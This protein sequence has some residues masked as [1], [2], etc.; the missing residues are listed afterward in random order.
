MFVT[1]LGCFDFDVSSCFSLAQD[2]MH[3]RSKGILG[4]LKILRDILSK[5][6][7]NWSVKYSAEWLG[8]LLLL[9]DIDMDMEKSRENQEGRGQP[10]VSERLKITQTQGIL[11][12]HLVVVR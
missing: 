1:F 11:L 10:V 2:K 7:C 8:L 3:A 6:N 5:H 12:I 4:Q 9:F